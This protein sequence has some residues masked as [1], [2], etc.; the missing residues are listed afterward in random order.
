[1]H[2]IV[3]MRLHSREVRARR[4]VAALPET[5]EQTRARQQLAG[6]RFGGT[7]GGLEATSPA[8][9]CDRQLGDHQIHPATVYVGVIPWQHGQYARETA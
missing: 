2:P 4:A 8:V 1:M 7:R 3:A 5:P 9:L 6:L